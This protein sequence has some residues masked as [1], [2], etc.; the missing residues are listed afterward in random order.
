MIF[1]MD[2]W[3][4][5]HRIAIFYEHITKENLFLQKDLLGLYK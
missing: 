5:G 3:N 2:Q 1:A 4:N